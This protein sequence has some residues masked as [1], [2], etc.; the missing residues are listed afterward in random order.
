MINFGMYSHCSKSDLNIWRDLG[1]EGW[2]WDDIIPYFQ[3]VEH[4][5][6]PSD[7]TREA[8]NTE[9][10]QP[11]LRGTS[12]MIQTSFPKDSFTWLQD[13][14]TKTSKS[15]GYPTVND[16]RTGTSLGLFNQLNTVDPK[17]S[18]RSYA[19]STYLAAAE[20]RPNLFVVTETF[21]KQILWS[22][23]RQ[24]GTVRAS[25]VELES[26]GDSFVVE[27]TKEV[28]ITAGSVQ[29][30]QILELSGIGQRKVLEKHGIEVVVENHNV[31][32]NLQDHPMV[33]MPFRAKEGVATLEALREHPELAAQFMDMYVKTGTGPFAATPTCTGFLSKQMVAPEV[34]LSH[35]M[36][37]GHGLP[38]RQLQLLKAQIEDSK[39][40][41]YQAAVMAAGIDATKRAAQT[42]MWNHTE[43]GGYVGLGFGLMHAFSRGSVH[44]ASIDITKHPDVY[45]RYLS[46]PMDLELLAH[47]TFH[48]KKIA[49][50]SPM[51]DSIADDPETGEKALGFGVEPCRTMEEAKEHVKK[52]QV[53][54]YHSTGTC[55][56]LPR[57]EGGVVDTSL[58]VYDAENVRIVDASIFPMNVQG[59]TVSLVY[60]VAEKAA[61]IVRAEYQ[62]PGRTDG[63][64]GEH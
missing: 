47:A 1:N 39:E 9:Y 54:M 7:E 45:P 21:V 36:K 60:A 37:A 8:L 27:A 38:E 25:G 3:K 41:E 33:I 5:H 63:V 6:I 22:A 58:R 20:G 51:A 24:G 42:G 57:E 12:G 61:D 18:K 28:L 46:H 10:I 29:S 15:M 55:S 31:G 16:P 48:A 19:A 32:E 11:G 62:F 44:I 26:G 52:R 64:N 17:T 59:N 30:P 43:P 4:M 40:A 34:D 23:V 49:A 50:T 13:A 56:M 35:L 2:G 14:W 53:T